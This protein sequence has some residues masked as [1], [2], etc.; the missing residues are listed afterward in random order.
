MADDRYVAALR[1]EREGYVRRG[2][3]DRV[4]EVDAEL[5]RVGMKPPEPPQDAPAKATRA[6]RQTRG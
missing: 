5:K 6:P 1:R 4:A 3:K 2:L